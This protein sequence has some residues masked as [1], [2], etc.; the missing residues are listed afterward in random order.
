MWL[1]AAV[2]LILHWAVPDFSLAQSFGPG[3]G[4]A[5]MELVARDHAQHPFS[6]RRSLPDSAVCDALASRPHL[7]PITGGGKPQAP[8]SDISIPVPPAHTAPAPVAYPFDF[9]P[10]PV[11]AFHSRAPPQLTS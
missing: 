8:A 9:S 7:V 2:A 3:A 4:I 6:L 5:P 11:T 1:I 10:R